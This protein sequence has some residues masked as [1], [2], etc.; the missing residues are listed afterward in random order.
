MGIT[1]ESVSND[2]SET[3]YKVKILKFRERMRS[4]VPGRSVRLLKSFRVADCKLRLVIYPNGSDIDHKGWVSVFLE[5]EA[6]EPIQIKFQLKITSII[7]DFDHLLNP[8]ELWG[9]GNFYQHV[10]G[11][12]G[13]DE[14]DEDERLTIT[15]TVAE[16]WTK[17][18][19]GFQSS[20][21]LARDTMRVAKETRNEVFHFGNSLG[22][23]RSG[24]VRPMSSDK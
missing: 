19:E 4:W 22:I 10:G 3:T 6:E 11:V 13:D 16:I 12:I 2:G 20:H 5:N 17:R 1:D 9:S 24:K 8:G 15:C 21:Q 7:A 14:D 23:T 18:S